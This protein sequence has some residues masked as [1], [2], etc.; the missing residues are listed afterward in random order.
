MS[1][2]TLKT[3]ARQLGLSVTTVSRALKDGDDVS[4]E[5]IE[6]VKER[7]RLVGYRPN[8]R[9]ISLRT[10][11]TS[12]ICAIL[13]VPTIGDLGDIGFVALIE[14]IMMA[15]QETQY[16]L[17]VLPQLPG[18]EEMG[19]IRNVVE[20]QMAD[21]LIF[22]RTKPQD[23]RAKYLIEKKFP[24]VAFGRTELFTPFPYLDIDNEEIGY[25]ATLRLIGLGH[26]RIALINPPR[27]YT[28][29]GHRV[30]GYRRALSER[31]LP[32]DDALI[33]YNDLG[34]GA[35]RAAAIDLCGIADPPTAYVCANALSV[36]GLITGL[37]ECGREIG[38]D[39]TVIGFDGTPMTAYY[40]PPIT[41]YYASLPDAGRRL[42][43]L[44]IEAIAGA[45]PATLRE[46][47]KAELIERQSDRLGAGL[48]SQAAD[49]SLSR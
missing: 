5:T 29:S 20:A 47:W 3:L 32:F 7:A 48:R 16:S 4:P 43:E 34:A 39:A 9:G 37:R 31:A 8:L 15:L 17:T 13:P 22:T 24:F 28:Y 30:L 46:V 40:N 19:H 36:M 1:R 41:T 18:D 23:E 38:R 42:A 12:R 27:E 21:G 6:L 44:L 14:G 45:D 49:S 11:R 35:G 26:R 10:G 33:H 2:P 25:E